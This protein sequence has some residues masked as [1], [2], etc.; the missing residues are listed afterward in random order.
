MFGEHNGQENLFWH[1]AAA[2]GLPVSSDSSAELLR[3]VEKGTVVTSPV[4]RQCQNLHELPHAGR[5]ASTSLLLDGNLQQ[6]VIGP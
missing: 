1:A 5:P 2:S 3:P 6:K 4:T